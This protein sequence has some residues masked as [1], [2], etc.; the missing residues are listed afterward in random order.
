MAELD[1]VVGVFGMKV[2]GSAFEAVIVKVF[3]E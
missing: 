1:V 3:V 2:M